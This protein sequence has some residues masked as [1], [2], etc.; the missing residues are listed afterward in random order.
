[1]NRGPENRSNRQ[2][3]DADFA[4]RQI[5]HAQEGPA[6][7]RRTSHATSSREDEAYAAACLAASTGTSEIVLNI[8]EAIL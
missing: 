7:S 3:L 4:P 5:L 8:C 6:A 1:M 2:R